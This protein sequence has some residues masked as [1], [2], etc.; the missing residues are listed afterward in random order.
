[1]LPF[2]SQLEMTAANGDGRHVKVK[3]GPHLYTKTH[4]ILLMHEKKGHNRGK[5]EG[6]TIMREVDTQKSAGCDRE[7]QRSR[8]V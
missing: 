5:A 4:K 6:S 1:M 2:P 8:Q 7:E 3:V